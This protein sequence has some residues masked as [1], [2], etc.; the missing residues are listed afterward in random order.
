ML[1]ISIS[2][3]AVVFPALSVLM[4][5]YT[6]RFIAISKRTRAL[7][8]EYKESPSENIKAQILSLS[9]RLVYIRNTQTLGISGF[10][11]NILS[12]FFVLIGLSYVGTILFSVSLLFIVISL[13][14]CVLE[15][16]L[17]VQAMRLL[18]NDDIMNS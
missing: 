11:I 7:H 9:K 16:H 10:L 8:A 4:L 18:L 17:S 1:D 15:I 14:I 6:N 12:I 13:I 2:T 3:P 5:A